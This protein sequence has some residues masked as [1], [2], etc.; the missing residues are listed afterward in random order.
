MKELKEPIMAKFTIDTT[1]AA[2]HCSRCNAESNGYVALL[3]CLK[4]LQFHCVKVCD[5]QH[6]REGCKPATQA[7]QLAVSRSGLLPDDGRH[8]KRA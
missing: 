8:E 7:Q 4:C 2:V 5:A 3:R 6:Q 1:G